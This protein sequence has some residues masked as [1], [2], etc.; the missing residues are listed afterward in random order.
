MQLIELGSEV[1]Y[2]EIDTS[3][4][5]YTFSVKLEDRTYSFTIRYNDVGGFFT[6]DL[7][8]SATG[9]ADPCLALS[10]MSVSRCPSSSLFALPATTSTP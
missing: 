8:I 2:I 1:Q 10:R 9:T 7:S 3:K 5:P 4:V 6:A